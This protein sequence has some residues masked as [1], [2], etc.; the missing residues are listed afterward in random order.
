MWIWIR[1]KVKTR[2]LLRLKIEPLRVLEA[3]NG[4]LEA[5]NGGSTDQW[6]R[7]RTLLMKKFYISGIEL[8]KWSLVFVIFFLKYIK[9]RIWE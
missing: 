6:S 8:Q 1:I 2:K 3:H 5:Q 9:F 4:G 7:I